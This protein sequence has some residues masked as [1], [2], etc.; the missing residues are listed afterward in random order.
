[1][2][3]LFNYT[4]EPLLCIKRHRREKTLR[5]KVSLNFSLTPARVK[6]ASFPP[7][8][9]LQPPTST[10]LILFVNIFDNCRRGSSYTYKHTIF[11]LP[12]PLSRAMIFFLHVT[13]FSLNFLLILRFSL[14]FHSLSCVMFLW[15]NLIFQMTA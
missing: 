10:K 11:S 9:E 15:N 3:N 5:A 4:C 7:T 2:Y 12:L 13:H 8:F 1:M 14:F 6:K